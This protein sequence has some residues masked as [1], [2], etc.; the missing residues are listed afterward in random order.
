MKDSSKVR[1]QFLFL[2]V[3]ALFA[4]FLPGMV[5]YGVVIF[6]LSMGQFLVFGNAMKYKCKS[7]G[8]NF[9]T[10]NNSGYT[11]YQESA[12]QLVLLNRCANCGKSL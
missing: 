9:C 3:L 1:L 8:C 2:V 6:I 12:L 11:G 7:C 5:G 10:V 4:L